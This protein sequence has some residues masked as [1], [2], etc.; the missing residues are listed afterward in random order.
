MK[1]AL[2]ILA[3]GASRRFGPGD[4]LLAL[5]DGKPLV[6]RTALEMAAV[7]VPRAAV[8]TIAVIA[9]SIGP[10]ATALMATAKLTPRKTETSARLEADGGPRGTSGAIEVTARVQL[11]QDV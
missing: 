10:V 1:I 5:V 7:R 11:R 8:A 2:I 4:K 9:G 6:I 3:A